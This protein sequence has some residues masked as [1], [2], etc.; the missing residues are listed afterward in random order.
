MSGSLEYSLDGL[1]GE[2]GVFEDESLAEKPDPPRANVA[3]WT[4]PDAVAL[5]PDD[6]DTAVAGH[7]SAD[8]FDPSEVP[9]DPSDDPPLELDEFRNRDGL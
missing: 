6:P 2:G 8:H 3:D 1:F 4:E 9:L 7:A 5:S